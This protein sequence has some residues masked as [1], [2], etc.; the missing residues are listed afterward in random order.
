VAAQNAKIANGVQSHTFNVP[1]TWYKKDDLL[2]LARALKISMEENMKDLVAYIKE[3]LH[4]HPELKENPY[5]AGL[6]L[7]FSRHS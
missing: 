1:I 7:R 4:N 5:F 2:T 6:F 3:H